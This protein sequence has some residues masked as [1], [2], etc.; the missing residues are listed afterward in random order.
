MGRSP[1]FLHRSCGAFELTAFF[2]SSR[3][4]HTRW[5]RDWS[6][7][8]CSSDLEAGLDPLPSYTPPSRERLSGDTAKRFPL[9]LITGDREKSY[10]HSRFRDQPWALKVSPDPRLT[11]HPATEIG[12]ASCRERRRHSVRGG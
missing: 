2:F 6:S 3:R 10:H 4:R 1:N 7:D 11:M 5:P 9:I 8:V 12:R